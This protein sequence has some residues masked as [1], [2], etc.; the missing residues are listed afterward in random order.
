MTF[1]FVLKF[2]YLLQSAIFISSIFSCQAFTLTGSH[3]F[4]WQVE[5]SVCSC[6]SSTFS[7]FPAFARLSLPVLL[8]S[9]SFGSLGQPWSRISAAFC[10]QPVYTTVSACIHRLPT[11]RAGWCSSVVIFFL[12]PRGF[13]QPFFSF[14]STFL[15]KSFSL[16]K[17]LS[18]HSFAFTGTFQLPAAAW[19]LPPRQS[20]QSVST[21]ML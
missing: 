7:T 6:I 20:Q 17:G 2:I 21:F 14:T 1:W 16:L 18:C 11:F 13:Q 15:L 4:H 19:P 9:S 3:H 12:S 8:V 5:Q 10:I